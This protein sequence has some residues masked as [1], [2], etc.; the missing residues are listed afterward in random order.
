MKTKWEYK[1]LIE[2]NNLALRNNLNKHGDKG[3][4]AF[5]VVRIE[6]PNDEA[7]IAYLKRRKD[8]E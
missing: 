6:Y 7:Y 2:A 3:W 8:K 1:T 5:S 4:E